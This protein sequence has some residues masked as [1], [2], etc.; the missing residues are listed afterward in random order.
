MKVKINN[1]YIKIVGLAVLGLG[2]SY[3]AIA[4]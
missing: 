4:Q 3:Q 2:I 1:S